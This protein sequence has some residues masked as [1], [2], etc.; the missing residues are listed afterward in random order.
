MHD[1]AGDCGGDDARRPA[2]PL[3]ADVEGCEPAA[4]GGWR[5]KEEWPEGDGKSKRRGGKSTLR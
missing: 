2:Q 5:E 1:V 4:A 3:L